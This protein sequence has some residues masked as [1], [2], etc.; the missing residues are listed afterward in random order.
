M[1]QYRLEGRFLLRGH[2]ACS[3]QHSAFLSGLPSHCLSFYPNKLL[4]SSAQVAF[5]VEVSKDNK[6]QAVNLMPPNCEETLEYLAS[7]RRRDAEMTRGAPL[8]PRSLR[9]VNNGCAISPAKRGVTLPVPDPL[10]HKAQKERK[11]D[12]GE[13]VRGGGASSSSARPRGIYTV[14]SVGWTSGPRGTSCGRKTLVYSSDTNIIAFLSFDE[15][16]HSN[17][18]NITRITKE[19]S[20]VYCEELHFG[21]LGRG[22]PLLSSNPHLQTTLP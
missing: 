22:P 12:N 16:P 17:L 10:Y 15:V 11:L 18:F 21:K 9:R 4:R 6:P 2:D 8:S 3:L 7:I 5:L 14:D 19:D 1:E 13:R 20:Y